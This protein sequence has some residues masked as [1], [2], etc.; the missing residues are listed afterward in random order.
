MKKPSRKRLFKKVHE[1][2]KLASAAHAGRSADARKTTGT[3]SAPHEKTLAS[4][5]RMVRR[6]TPD[7]LP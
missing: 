3:E 4:T 2:G 7:G 6:V 5:R 1:E